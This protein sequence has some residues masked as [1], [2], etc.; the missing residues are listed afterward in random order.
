MNETPE[1]PSAEPEAHD[2]AAEPPKQLPAPP[3]ARRRRNLAPWVYA[4]AFV[5]LGLALLWIWQNPMPSPNAV[6][7]QEVDATE[8]ELHS[9]EAKVAVLEQRQGPAPVNLTP[10]EQR[11]AALEH[12][13]PEQ[14]DLAPIEAQITSLKAQ[15][16]AASV[17]GHGQ[18]VDLAPLAQR[19]TA[20]EHETASLHDLAG[21]ETTLRTQIAALTS[22]GDRQK[23]LDQRLTQIATAQQALTKQ[24]AELDTTVRN[25]AKSLDDR[26][27][28]L[29]DQATR[30]AA[31][32]RTASHLARLQAARAA[33]SAGEPLGA[34]DNAPAALA[35]FAT[36]KP[37][38][39]ADL[40]LNFPAAAK[41][42]LAASQPDTADAPFGQRL[43]RRA[44]RLIT[45]R[46]GD[47]V[48]VGDPAAGILARAQTLLDV[49]DL[50]GAVAA[51]SSL[52]G[53]P[54]QAM[55]P[56]LEQ[57]RALLAAQQAL[58]QMSKQA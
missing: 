16:A 45:V 17:P 24:V 1:P 41:N 51:V 15:V 12:H 32:A 29:S 44:Q 27:Q 50:G 31:E 57:A 22:V 34:I 3:S 39:E 9:V 33:L 42:A 54:A 43:W 11:V 58:E 25:G 30:A 48:I 13:Q 26:L 49:D 4:L 21:Q 10:L 52:S 18:T 37:P 2:S 5:I 8:Q 40:R 14:A 23:E 55:A 20:L 47:R 28:A 36:T 38:T 35:R 6:Q 53:P 56:W 46:E 19:V 7:P